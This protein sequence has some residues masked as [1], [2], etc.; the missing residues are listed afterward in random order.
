M[1]S[2]QSTEPGPPVDE[3]GR[4]CLGESDV[5]E[6]SVD[7][8]PRSPRPTRRRRIRGADGRRAAAEDERRRA[9]AEAAAARTDGRGSSTK[10]R[11]TTRGRG[12]RPE[13]ADDAADDDAEPADDAP[14]TDPLEEF[15]AALRSKPGDWFV[16]PH[17]L[18]HGE[19]GQDQPR[20]PHLLPQH[21]GLHLRGP[22][23]AGGGLGDQER[24][25]QAG[26]P[27]RAPRLCAGPHGAHRRVLVGRPAHAV[28]DRLRRPQPPAGAAEPRR[29]RG[30]ARPGRRSRKPPDGRRAASSRR[31]SS[32]PTSTPAT[33]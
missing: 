18:R 16:D 30:D 7:A 13:A 19:P 24:P 5:D 25:A 33:R 4:D 14:A 28:G 23:A 1:T 26:Q 17:L 3:R 27:H 6:A 32:S 29:G 31:R 12:R 22:R 21:G 11:P 2:Q 20:E 15:R 8:A 10:P 9:A